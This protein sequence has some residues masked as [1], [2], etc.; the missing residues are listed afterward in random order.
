[1]KELDV[2]EIDGKEY[3]IISEIEDNN[4]KYVF[5]CNVNN[6]KDFCV[7]KKV[8]VDNE[9][10]LSLLDNDLEFDKVVELFSKKYTS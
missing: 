7:R 5:L 4:N 1:M 9:E 8:F 3:A 6:P 2:F 10:F